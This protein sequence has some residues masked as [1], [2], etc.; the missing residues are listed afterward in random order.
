MESSSFQKNVLLIAALSNFLTPF[1]GSSV[2]VSLPRIGRDLSMNV[3]T[4][5][6]VST[7]YLVAAA[8]FLVPCGRASDIYGR[9]KIFLWGIVLDS[10]SSLAGACAASSGMLLAARVFQ[11]MG[12]A[13]IFTMGVSIIASVFPV[14]E[15]GRAFGISVAAVYTGLSAGPFVGGFLTHYVGW[16]SIFVLNA[17]IGATILLITL[18][19]LKGEWVEAAG[20][21]FDAAGSL[22]CM[23]SLVSIMYG[24]STI[25]ASS[26]FLL[27]ICGALGVM[28][29]VFWEMRIESPVL[30][31]RL[32]QRSRTFLFSNLAALINYSATFAIMFLISLYLQYIK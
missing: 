17:L 10:A 14:E 21:K 8:A 2:I 13:M 4:L 19:K 20:E 9:K 22:I 5:S 16:R 23:A 31:M 24:L 32:F 6:W 29:F 26:G 12:G 3:L 1:M 27:V 30:E 7:A 18:S 15:R 25:P 28:L 11:G